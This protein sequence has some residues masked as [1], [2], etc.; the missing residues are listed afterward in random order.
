MCPPCTCLN[1]VPVQRVTTPNPMSRTVGL[2]L[3]SWVIHRKIGYEEEE[4]GERLSGVIDK[5]T[6]RLS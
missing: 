2:S 4:G 1:N 3:K 6:L 5:Y